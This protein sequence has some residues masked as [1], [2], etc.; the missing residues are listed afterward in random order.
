MRSRDAADRQAARERAVQVRE[1]A[2][3]ERARFNRATG[4]GARVVIPTAFGP[5]RVIR[6][7]EDWW[8]VCEPATGGETRTFAGCNDGTWSDMLEQARVER[9]PLFRRA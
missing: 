5:Y 2:A 7:R 1:A 9:A 3:E 4:A 8:Y 6:V